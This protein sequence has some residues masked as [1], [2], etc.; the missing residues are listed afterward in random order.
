MTEKN[1]ID[2]V[3]LWVDGNDPEWRAKR[4]RADKNLSNGCRGEMALYS[5]V[6]GRFRDNDEL[7][8]SLRALTRFFPEHG[9]IY[10]VTD[11]Q[12]PKWLK[13]HSGLTIIDHRQLIPT[14]HLPIFDSGN[15]ESYLHRIADLSERFFYFNDDVF[16]GAP[17]DVNDWF[18]PGGIYTAWSD[19]PVVPD[20]PL[21]QDATSPENGCRLSQHWLARNVDDKGRL[22]QYRHTPRTFAHGPR[23]ML[24]SLLKTL[25]VVA[26]E[27]FAD[28]R[29]T[30]FRVWDKPT[31]VSDFVLRWAL[32]H[33]VARLQDY[34]HQYISTGSADTPL[35][36]LK[37]QA[38]LGGLSFFCINDTLDDAHRRDPRLIQVRRVLE[39]MLG[40]A[41]RFEK[42]QPKLRGNWLAHQRQQMETADSALQVTK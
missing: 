2:I 32:A 12:T 19:D 34:P 22:P 40:D 16:F 7:R 25:E 1:N 8:Y 17:V 9:H 38:A 42:A 13:A 35:E 36:L 26:P 14:E 41:S 6:E 10:I 28:V 30:R 15:I 5:N 18:W 11:A 21:L 3:Y 39:S 24:R 27:L 37:L 29:S 20:G 33:G 23:P 31:I 4:L